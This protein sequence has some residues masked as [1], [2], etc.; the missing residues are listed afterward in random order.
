[1]RNV[2]PAISAK[3]LHL[4]FPY[5][6]RQECAFP[7]SFPSFWRSFP[8]YFPGQSG[9]RI[10]R[11]ISMNGP[12]CCEAA[13]SSGSAFPVKNGEIEW[14]SLKAWAT[15]LSTCMAYEIILIT[16]CL[17]QVHRLVTTRTRAKPIWFQ[18]LRYSSLF[19]SCQGTWSTRVFPSWTVHYKRNGRRR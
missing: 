6:Q 18:V 11:F 4:F 7:P 3:H 15:T 1:M 8:L 16:D 12:C 17:P 13:R 14:W 19:G 9:C 10:T 5:E 2:S